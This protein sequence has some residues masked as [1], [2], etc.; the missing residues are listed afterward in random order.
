[1]SIGL[2]RSLSVYGY[3]RETGQEST[4]PLAPLLKSE[5]NGSTTTLTCLKVGADYAQSQP[6]DLPTFLQ[7]TAE[8]QQELVAAGLHVRISDTHANWSVIRDGAKWR[9]ILLDVGRCAV[10]K[11]GGKRAAELRAQLGW[12]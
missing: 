9:A 1:M 7:I 12:A 2:R 3:L 6:I 5:V 8:S 4:V 11:A 10:S